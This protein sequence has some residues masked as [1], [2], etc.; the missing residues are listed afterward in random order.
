LFRLNDEDSQIVIFL[1]VRFPAKKSFIKLQ[2]KAQ[3]SNCNNKMPKTEPENLNLQE[4]EVVN[5][6][7]DDL[8]E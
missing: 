2:K 4:S 1:G 6:I 5:L 3:L 8:R 7:F